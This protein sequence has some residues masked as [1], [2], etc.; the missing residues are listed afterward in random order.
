[1]AVQPD[2]VLVVDRAEFQHGFLACGIGW[3]VQRQAEPN[4]AVEIRQLG[5]RRSVPLQRLANRGPRG[6]VQGLGGPPFFHPGIVLGEPVLLRVRAGSP[7]LGLKRC[8]RGIEITD[9]FQPFLACPGFRDGPAPRGV[10]QPDW[11]FQFLVQLPAEVVAD[12]RES[13]DGLR[14]TNLPAG[15]GES[16][17]R[18]RGGDV[19][20]GDRADLRMIRGGDFGLRVV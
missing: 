5:H 10:D 4:D 18:L 1:M 19:R 8:H 17:L 9:R 14:R 6:V 11:H 13:A 12:R 7:G 2:R 3:N 15:A 20:Q 16:D